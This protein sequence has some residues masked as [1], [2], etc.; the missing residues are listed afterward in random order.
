MTIYKGGN[1]YEFMWKDFQDFQG[2]YKVLYPL[3]VPW[4]IAGTIKEQMQKYEKWRMQEYK[5]YKK[6]GGGE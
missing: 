1:I 3:E 2:H 4:R 5:D 6:K